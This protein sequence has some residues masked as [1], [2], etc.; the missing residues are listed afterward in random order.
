MTLT[1]KLK[2]LTC[3]VTVGV[4]MAGSA[5]AEDRVL[6]VTNWGEYIAEDTIANFEKEYGIKVIYDTYD[7]A[8]SI[9][10]KLLAGNSGY[11]VVSHAGSDT[12]RLI[13]AGIIAPLDKSKLDNI[14]HIDP[15]I[16]EQLASEWDPG[17]KHFIPYMWGTHG[18]TYNEELV[19]ATYPDAPIGSMD[20]I[21]NPEHLEKVAGC[22][23]SF[24]DSPGDIIPMALAYLGLDP[25]ST[26]AEDY[27]AV[28]EMLAQIRPHIKTFDNYAYQRMPQKEF[29]IS[30]TWGP[31]GL[32]AMSGAAEAE[33]G[34]VLDF[35]LPEGE[36]K[37][38]L[39]IDGW[40]IPADAA[41][42]EDAHLFLNYMMRPEVGAADSN[43]TWYATANKTGKELVDEE[44]TSS[45]AAFPTSDQV[46]KMYTT[47][48]LPPKVERLQTRTWTNFK[49]GN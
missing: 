36:G 15:A 14:K 18:V 31:D 16:M 23:V 38:Q 22:G 41:N 42:K 44:V 28:G 30:T 5:I 11:D 34:V 25:N 7:S 2:G 39:W 6:K 49:A 10:A 24:L 45:P 29:C 1:T 33:T 19:K 12:A 35:F 43:F 47:K 8:E 40:V 46:A 37:A 17:N 32:L 27:E 20:L 21:F 3:T 4:L 48:V 9:D 13:K 26:N